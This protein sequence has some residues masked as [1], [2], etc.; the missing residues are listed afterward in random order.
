LF[1]ATSKAYSPPSVTPPSEV[2]LPNDGSSSTV[3]PPKVTAPVVEGP[4]TKALEF[5]SP[6]S[7]VALKPPP[8]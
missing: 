6:S 5:N 7:G 2:P 1:S 8:E 3:S 4:A